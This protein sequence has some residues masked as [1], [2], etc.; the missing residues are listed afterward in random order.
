[1]FIPVIFTN[2]ELTNN[3]MYRVQDTNRTTLNYFSVNIF[4]AS[5]IWALSNIRLESGASRYFKL[6]NIIISSLSVTSSA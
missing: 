1:M 3:K 2:M 6:Y 5:Y 4:M